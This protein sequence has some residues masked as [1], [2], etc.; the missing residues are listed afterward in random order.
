MEYHRFSISI[1]LFF[2]LIGCTGKHYPDAS[3]IKELNLNSSNVTMDGNNMIIEFDDV[4]KLNDTIKCHGLFELCISDDINVSIITNNGI[5]VQAKKTICYYPTIWAP[6]DKDLI[7]LIYLYD[8]EYRK[9]EDLKIKDG[10]FTYPSSYG[11]NNDK[12]ARKFFGAITSQQVKTSIRTI[13]ETYKSKATLASYELT[14]WK[15]EVNTWMDIVQKKYRKDSFTW[16]GDLFSIDP[17]EV[18]V[19]ITFRD[20]NGQEITKIF[21]DRIIVGN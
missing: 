3:T 15:K 14:S 7:Q 5:P 11:L 2:L 1:S 10:S 8:L 12:E 21:K 17:D 19:E 16:Q 6:E 4:S 13:P 20:N 9:T 18:F